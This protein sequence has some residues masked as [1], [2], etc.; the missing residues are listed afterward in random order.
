[1]KY[2]ENSRII[3]ALRSVA[4][5]HP[6]VQETLNSAIHPTEKGKRGGSL[7]ICNECGLCFT[8]KEVQVDHIDPV[9]PVDREI[10]DWNEY[11]ER[12]FCSTDKLQVLCK[13]CHQ[14]KCNEENE[15]RRWQKKYSQ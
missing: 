11:I 15:E 1:M 14:I 4:K 12:L 2:N 5:F 13:P 3:G 8:R 10:V 7:F 6:N 9:V